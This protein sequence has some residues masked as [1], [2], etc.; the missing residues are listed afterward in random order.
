MN[1]IKQRLEE[2]KKW[3]PESQSAQLLL[4]I[5]E[6][7]ASELDK[8]YKLSFETERIRRVT[9]QELGHMCREALEKTAELLGCDK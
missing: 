7:Q 1:K 9:R 5:I 3:K 2:L 8:M 6:L 4:T